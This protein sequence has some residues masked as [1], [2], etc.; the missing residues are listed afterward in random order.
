MGILSVMI[1]GDS[2]TVIKKCQTIKP[3]K[4][5]IGVI[6]RDIQN[7]KEKKYY[8]RERKRTSRERLQINSILNQ[9]EDGGRTQ[10]KGFF[11]E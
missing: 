7:K 3:N 8:E 9:R 11:E 4:S 2:R 1:Q 5:A 10:T 6:I